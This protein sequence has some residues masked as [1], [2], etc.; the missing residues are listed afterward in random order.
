MSDMLLQPGQAP[1]DPGSVPALVGL[2]PAIP[3]NQ[4]QMK[5]YYLDT[6][7][8]SILRNDGMRITFRHKIAKTDN[9]AD[10]RYLDEQ[11]RM[12]AIPYLRLATDEEA[13]TYEMTINPVA[14]IRQDVAAEIES[15]MSETVEKTREDARAEVLKQLE[16][17]GVAIPDKLL[18]SLQMPATRPQLASDQGGRIGLADV[19]DNSA[20]AALQ[21]LKVGGTE[22]RLGGIVSTTD[23]GS[24]Q[25]V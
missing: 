16:N 9:T 25:G 3:Y 10:H 12:R 7:A 1:G 17:A 22:V 11:I 21:R 20:Y 24:N 8:A 15:Q 18:K 6:M 13:H 23:L 2:T 14:T 5:Y 4:G 19:S